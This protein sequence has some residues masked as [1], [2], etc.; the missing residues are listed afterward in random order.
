MKIRN[1]FVSNSSSSSF[2]IR[3]GNTNTS[4]TSE[5]PKKKF[6]FEDD[7]RHCDYL[8]WTSEGDD[9][10]Q[11]CFYHDWEERDKGTE[12]SKESCPMVKGLPEKF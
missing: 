8:L 5:P 1:G 11:A 4:E 7:F 2:I 6:I 9:E 3:T 10:Y 12:C